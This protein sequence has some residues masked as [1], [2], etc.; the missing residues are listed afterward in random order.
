VR[1]EGVVVGG[2]AVVPPPPARRGYPWKGARSGLLPLLLPWL[3]G[4]ER[5]PTLL[6]AHGLLVQ[7]DVPDGIQWPHASAAFTAHN[8]RSTTPE[9]FLS[10]AHLRCRVTGNMHL[11]KRF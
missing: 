9:Y 4:T 10:H 3:V 6:V 11:A 5:L 1:R 7:P 2:G 8:R